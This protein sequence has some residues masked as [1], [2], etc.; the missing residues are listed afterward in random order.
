MFEMTQYSPSQSRA[1]S[2][3]M[4]IGIHAGLVA[5]ALIPWTAS[6][7]VRPVLNDTAVVLYTPRVWLPE[8]TQGGGG[9]GKRLPTPASRG[10]LPRGADKQL[11]PPTVEPPKN[12][13]PSLVV[14]ST[15]VAP[16]LALRPL[17]LLNIGDPNGVVGP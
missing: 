15:I 12:P 4:S 11:A 7:H 16:Q 1:A 10:E 13:D 5:L 2:R 17:N 8:H 14:E 6:I 9:G 3:L